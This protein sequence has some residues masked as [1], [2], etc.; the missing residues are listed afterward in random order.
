LHRKNYFG[1]IS[2]HRYFPDFGLFS[3]CKKRNERE[4]KAFNSGMG[5]FADATRKGIKGENDEKHF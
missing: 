3:Q 2:P 5:A 4:G 1:T